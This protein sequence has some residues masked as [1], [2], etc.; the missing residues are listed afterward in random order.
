MVFIRLGCRIIVLQQVSP[1]STSRPL[2]P[3][4]RPPQSIPY[5]LVDVK[6]GA[7]MWCGIWAGE[8]PGAGK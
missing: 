3:L 2:H 6:G 8:S 4:Y 5:F 1:S 7:V